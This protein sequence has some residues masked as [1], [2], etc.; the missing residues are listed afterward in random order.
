MK[1]ARAEEKTDSF[2]KK[3]NSSRTSMGQRKRTQMACEKKVPKTVPSQR[4]GFKGGFNF[5]KNSITELGERTRRS[6]WNL[7]PTEGNGRNNETD[8]RDR[9]KIREAQENDIQKE[10][11]EKDCLRGEGGISRVGSLHST[12]FSG[13]GDEGSGAEGWKVLGNGWE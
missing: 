9:E 4:R 1:G 8:L 11:G 10:R 3:G 2:L 13:R 7:E 12:G 6:V 5:C